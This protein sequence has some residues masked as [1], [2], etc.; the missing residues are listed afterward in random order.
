[1][2]PKPWG[3]VLLCVVL[4][5]LAGCSDD[6]PALS[7]E[8]SRYTDPGDGCPQVVSAIGYA[9]AALL[10][11]GQEPYQEWTDEVRSKLSAVDGTAALETRDFPSKR[12]LRQA[13]KLGDLAQ[14]AA[15]A[16]VKPSRRV[17]RLRVYRREAAEMV[18]ICAEDTAGR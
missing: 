3:P 5:P 11:P 6:R 1:V 18:I 17:T 2:R 10:A 13:R 4:L 8:L 12:A 7:D 16:G 14:A 15:A 9:D